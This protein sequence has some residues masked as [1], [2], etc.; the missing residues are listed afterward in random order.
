[1]TQI[2]TKGNQLSEKGQHF[3]HSSHPE[4][5]ATCFLCEMCLLTCFSRGTL[6]VYVPPSAHTSHH[7][8]CQEKAVASS[9][10]LEGWG[11]R[12]NW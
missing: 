8:G 1:M 3:F 10:G 2:I 4:Q 9:R 6:R 12:L 7:S 5:T 11:L